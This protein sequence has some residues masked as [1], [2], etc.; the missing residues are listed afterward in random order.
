MAKYKI[1]QDVES[2]EGGKF[3]KGEVLEGRINPK[4]D[5]FIIFKRKNNF[6]GE[7]T[8]FKT[9]IEK[10]D[11]STP[12]TNPADF[13]GALEESNKADKTL[14]IL[15]TIGGLAGLY[16]AYSKKKGMWGYV[17]F[18]VLGGIVGSL[19]ANVV[20]KMKKPKL[21]DA[22]KKVNSTTPTTTTTTTTTTTKAPSSIAPV[23]VTDTSKMTKA[24]KI[25]LIVKTMSDPEQKEMDVFNKNFIN[26]LS[27]AELNIWIKLSKAL[28]DDEIKKFNELEET[29]SN[30]NKFFKLFQS[31]YGLSQKQVEEQMKKFGEALMKGFEKG[32]TQATEQVFEQ[33]LKGSSNTSAF[34]NFESS[35]DL[36]I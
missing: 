5:G 18:M 23:S 11:D 9:E 16:Y 31:K 24:Q 17:G 1:L 12:L 14:T 22:T 36:D 3:F 13:K 32:M 4:I 25:D 28:K 33:G 20:T 27:D 30:K 29:P 34:S 15:S 2:A 26:T 35:L 19:V 6:S 21:A 8:L 7:N 10:V